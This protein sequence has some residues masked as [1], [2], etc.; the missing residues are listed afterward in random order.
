MPG[1]CPSSSIRS[2]TTPSYNWA[3]LLCWSRSCTSTVASTARLPDQPTCS[4][5]DAPPPRA[6][7]PR[8]RRPLA[9]PGQAQ[10]TEVGHAA[11]ECSGDRAELLLGELLSVLARVTHR[12]H[13]EI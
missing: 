8:H 11:A 7:G 5:P 13:D 12:G 10:S 3:R 1:R 4:R 2:W 6:A 9:E